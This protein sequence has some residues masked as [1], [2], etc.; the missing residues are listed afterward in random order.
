MA[1]CL[2]S[3]QFSSNNRFGNGTN[4]G[5]SSASNDENRLV[6]VIIIE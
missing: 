5:N 1:D 6:N 2:V 3:N 4:G